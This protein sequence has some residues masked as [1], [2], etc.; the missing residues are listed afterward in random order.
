MSALTL[1]AAVGTNGV[2]GV[3]GGLPWRLPA[4]LQHFKALTLGKPVLM[5]RR[6][7][8]SLGRP[9]PGRRNLVVTRQAG[10]AAA[11]A[12]VFATVEAALMAVA[13]QPEVMVIGGGELYKQLLPQAAVLELTEVAATLEG[14]A[15]F[16][17]FDAAIWPEVS[18]ELHAADERHAYAYTFVRR[19]R[20]PDVGNQNA[21]VGSIQLP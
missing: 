21:A 8:D 16:P 4:D 5:G 2:I 7:W 13:D 10:F 3:A 14:D 12:E 11:G 19:I 9:L 18:R 20:L 15:F 17:A 1:I 6:T